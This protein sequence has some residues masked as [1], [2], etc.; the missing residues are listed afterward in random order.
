MDPLASITGAA[1]ALVTRGAAV[2]GDIR[3]SEA[4]GQTVSL[5]SS[6]ALSVG[7]VTG[8]TTAITASG[9]SAILRGPVKA[10]ALTVTARENI[11]TNG[12]TASGATLNAS[13]GDVTL[14][15]T[16]R[17][18]RSDAPTG[19]RLSV[20]AAKAI[21]VTGALSATGGLALSAASVKT[22]GAGYIT[23]AD[24]AGALTTLRAD[25]IDVRFDT[26]TTTGNAL[27]VDARGRTQSSVGDARFLFNTG[28]AITF[29]NLWVHK[30]QVQAS[31]ALSVTNLAMRDYLLLGMPGATV[32]LVGQGTAPAATR[33]AQTGSLSAARLVVTPVSGSTP[34]V[35]VNG[36]AR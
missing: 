4:F 31:T 11:V 19:A 22:T 33:T 16:T 1:V 17:I 5:R 29:D 18:F 3:A 26:G 25:T 2:L 7:Q 27:R 20:T 28:R 21:E 8:G 23:D 15:G 14:N 34:T 6:G 10:G 24:L 30:G 36:V 32:A 9:G 12:I 35:S 13:T